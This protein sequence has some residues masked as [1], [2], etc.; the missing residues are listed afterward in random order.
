MARSCSKLCFLAALGAWGGLALTDLPP[1]W[2]ALA[3]VSVAASAFLAQCGPFR[4]A[5]F[6]AFA[7]WLLTGSEIA[8][9]GTVGT[10]FAALI[11][12]LLLA[13]VSFALFQDPQGLMV[14]TRENG[15]QDEE[16]ISDL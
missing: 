7:G 4:G 16:S 9:A 5:G 15:S 2:K 11:T 6:S 8:R 1:G 3:L 12:V 10:L 14:P 13:G